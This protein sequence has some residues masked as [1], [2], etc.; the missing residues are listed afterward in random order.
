[1][2][3]RPTGLSTT[4]QQP[5]VACRH[6]HH[7]TAPALIKRDLELGCRARSRPSSRLRIRGPHRREPCGVN[8]GTTGSPTQRVNRRALVCGCIVSQLASHLRR[9][10]LQVGKRVLVRMTETGVGWARVG[11]GPQNESPYLLHTRPG[12]DTG[13]IGRVCDVATGVRRPAFA[14]RT[15]RA[16]ALGGRGWG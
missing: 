3:L 10:V 15:G 2:D 8:V 1:M 14:A 4:P 11:S 6:A 9:G 16:V 12:C 13:Q 5:L 7:S